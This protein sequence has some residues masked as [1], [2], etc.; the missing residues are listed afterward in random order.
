MVLKFGFVFVFLR[1]RSAELT[2]IVQ[3]V[4]KRWYVPSVSLSKMR[5][6]SHTSNP[7]HPPPNP[8]PQRPAHHP[9]SSLQCCESRKQTSEYSINPS[10]LSS[11][12]N[13]LFPLPP[14]K[15]LGRLGEIPVHQNHSLNTS[16]IEGPP[17]LGPSLSLC[18]VHPSAFLL[19]FSVYNKKKFCMFWNERATRKREKMVCPFLQLI[20]SHRNFACFSFCQEI[21][22]FLKQGMQTVY[23]ATA[24]KHHAPSS[25]LC[26]THTYS[27]SASWT[28]QVSLFASACQ[29][30]FSCMGSTPLH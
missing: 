5:L 16:L 9:I 2:T 6:S 22:H 14:L 23:P 29:A 15:S 19:L 10:Y 20:I 4:E 13:I 1:S 21:Y 30:V 17:E 26:W 24:G 12:L 27:G 3:N 18:A 25:L 28:R 7:F 11:E 8:S